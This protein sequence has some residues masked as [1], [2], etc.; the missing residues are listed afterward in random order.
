MTFEKKKETLI[1]QIENTM[2]EAN[3]QDP[4][5]LVGNARTVKPSAM[6]ARYGRG[7]TYSKKIQISNPMH[8]IVIAYKAITDASPTSLIDRLRY[9]AAERPNFQMFNFVYKV[10]IPGLPGS[11]YNLFEC[12]DWNDKDAFEALA[13]QSPWVPIALSA[14][15]NVQ[16]AIPPAT[17]VK[18]LFAGGDDE[19]MVTDLRDPKIVE[20]GENIPKLIVP[21]MQK[22]PPGESFK[23]GAPIGYGAGEGSGAGTRHSG[24]EVA[25]VERVLK[26]SSTVDFG[27]NPLMQ[28]M[29]E[30]LNAAA[31]ELGIYL[32]SSSSTRSAYDQVRIMLDNYGRHGGRDYLLGLYGQGKAGL[33][34]I[35]DQTS[36]PK[37]DRIL[38]GVA[39]FY[40]PYKGSHSREVGTALDLRWA[41]STDGSV[42][43]GS[44]GGPPLEVTQALAA[45]A[46]AM[47]I[48]ILVE[49]DH[50]HIIAVSEAPGQSKV[51]IASNAYKSKA[52]EGGIIGKSSWTAH[53]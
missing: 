44:S 50:Y 17:S 30:A 34:D 4:T 41:F 7:D 25:G 29:L 23:L 42:A 51:K 31:A 22:P 15:M 46:R 6:I 53:V 26:G 2:I 28:T 35:F 49:K 5:G 43:R 21:A 3:L 9:S 45:A 18:V 37:K 12:E 32:V 52:A 1:C 11:T 47:S 48:K 19:E 33:A 38:D 36:R 14:G 39:G 16:G 13:A 20:I 8:G 24:P 27:P 40:N 10:W